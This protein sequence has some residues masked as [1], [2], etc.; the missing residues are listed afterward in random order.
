ML[1]IR[2]V[3]F[4]IA[5]IGYLSGAILV[6]QP[7]IRCIEVS[8]VGLAF[9]FPACLGIGL[10]LYAVGEQRARELRY[11]GWLLLL[12]GVAALLGIFIDAIGVL[13]ASQTLLLWLVSPVS[14]FV[15]IL[16]TF[17]A[18]VLERHFRTTN[19]G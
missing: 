16:L 2:L 10:P 14:L 6:V 15:G 19:G 8:S 4:L 11:S 18:E 9:L 7:F 13:R 3:G 5:A 1:P 17:F 12:I